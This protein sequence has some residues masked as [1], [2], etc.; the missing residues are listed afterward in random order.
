MGSYRI[1]IFFILAALSAYI[2]PAAA[3]ETQDAF[4]TNLIAACQ[5][6]DNPKVQELIKEHRLWVK[7][8]VNQ[9][10]ADYI[11]RTM[12]GSKA[13]AAS[14]KN[15]ATLISRTFKETYGEKSLSIATAYLDTWGMEQLG[16]KA[17][18]D[19]IFDIAED[20]RNDKQT[21]ESIERYDQALQLY[22]DI[23]DTRGEGEVFGRL[24][25]IY[26][27][28]DSDTCLSYYQKAL[29]ARKRVDDRV[30]V[31]ATLNSLGVVYLWK[32]GELDSAI[33]YLERACI[34]RQEIDDLTGY[35]SSL[36]YLALSYEYNGQ[37]VRAQDAY[38]K[39]YEVNKAVG[40][41]VKMAEALQNTASL[42]N[43]TG[44]YTE[45][46]QKL[47]LALELREELIALKNRLR[48]YEN[49]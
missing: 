20:L 47:K 30:L 21:K 16:K 25:L 39:A 18:A 5:E 45:A 12:T 13:R 27:A 11:H 26:W 3:Q 49:D 23:G 34:L 24:G 2:Q 37:Y 10:I 6:K 44:H 31:G 35:G 29:V 15:A 17:Q 40:N 14:L 38:L 42:L 19:R 8:V 43:I 22:L 36:V 4:A 7:P 1:T 48:L 33:Y 28:I 32:F 46:L 41:K 9:L